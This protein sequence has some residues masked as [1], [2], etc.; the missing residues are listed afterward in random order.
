MKKIIVLFL[1]VIFLFSCSTRKKVENVD[2]ELIDVWIPEKLSLRNPLE[3][4]GIYEDKVYYWS[5][6]GNKYFLNFYD[7]S[8]SNIKKLEFEM[9]KGP[10]QIFSNNSTFIKNDQ[11]NI[12]DLARR[13]LL[14]FDMNGKYVDDYKININDF[15]Q[16]ARNQNYLYFSGILKN[17]LAKIDLENNEVV[18]SIKYKNADSIKSFRDIMGKK[19]RMSSIIID[20]EAKIL[21]RGTSNLPYKIEKYDFNLEKIDEFKREITGN[22]KDFIIEEGTGGSGSIIISSMQTDD[23]YLYA[24]FGGGQVTERKNNKIS[25]S[26]IANDYFISVFDKK[27]GD[28]LYEINVPSISP[29]KGVTKLLKVTKDKLFIMV[30]DFEDTL[31]D[32]LK[33]KNLKAE[34]NELESRFISSDVKRA[35]V[36]VK[37][38]I[39]QD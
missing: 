11:I 36:I 28:F 7:L 1:L 23:K 19:L 35:I 12:L 33:D 31:N 21:Y 27:N 26:G 2:A 16:V 8:G 30:V 20:E 32:L 13:S 29:L 15:G 18:K 38:P 34:K 10:G 5:N 6:S 37:N 24:S 9:G 3:N 17:K 4:I 14:V 39:Y 25:L 22:F